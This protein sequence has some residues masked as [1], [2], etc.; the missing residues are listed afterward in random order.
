MVTYSLVLLLV[1]CVLSQDLRYNCPDD[2][3]TTDNTCYKFVFSPK[4]TYEK[5]R[6]TCADMFASLISITDLTEHNFIENY[7]INNDFYRNSWYTRGIQDFSG[8][9]S[10]YWDGETTPIPYTQQY[11]LPNAQKSPGVIIVYSYAVSKYGWSLAGKN[12]VLPYIC[13]I[14]RTFAY[15]LTMEKRTFEFGIPFQNLTNIQRGPI[16]QAQPES[17][18][19]VSRTPIANVECRA[20]CYPTCR[21]KWFRGLGLT[22]EVSAST[23]NRYTMTNGKLSIQDPDEAKDASTYQCQVSNEIGTVISNPVQLA[24][25]SLGEFSNV[26]DAPVFANAYEGSVIHCSHIKADPAA[27]YMWLRGNPP[28]EIITETTPYTFM[29]ANGRLY[30]SEVTLIDALD[31]YCQ[32]SLT[33]LTT[34]SLGTSQAPSR[35][36]R[37]I[38]MIVRQKAPM[39]N[40]GPDIQ[41]DFIYVSP[42]RP[43]KGFNVRMECFAYGSAVNY[44][45]TWRYQWSR[46]GG[47]IPQ[48]AK[49]SDFN[50]VM[51]IEN[52]QPEDEGNYLCI[53]SRGTTASSQKNLYLR[54]Y[55]VPYYLV[56]LRPQHVDLGSDLTW[57]CEASGYP[58]PTYSWY[59][60]GKLIEIIPGEINVA[61]NTLTI[62]NLQLKHNGMYQCAAENYLGTSMSEAQLRVLAF[63]PTFNKKPLPEEIY[64]AVNGNITI[65]C[66][67][68]AAPAPTIEWYI[69]ASLIS[70]TDKFRRELNGD[71]VIT[72]LGMADAGVY[73]CKATNDLGSTESA[74]RL[75]VKGQVAI[76]VPP[77]VTDKAVQNETKFIRCEAS[78]DPE[79]DLVYVWN[80]NGHRINIVKDFHY[81]QIVR[82]GYTGLMIKLIQFRHGGDYE[83]IAKTPV[84]EARASGFL[85]I[86]GPPSEPAGVTADTT[87]TTSLRLNWFP[88]NTNGLAVDY[89]TIQSRVQGEEGVMTDWDY[90][91]NDDGGRVFER[92]VMPMGDARADRRSYLVK[93]LKPGN[94]YQF[95]VAAKNGYAGISP[96]SYPS[97]LTKT[98]EAAPIAMPSLIYGGNGS[99]GDLHIIWNEMPYEDRGHQDGG[100]MVYWRQFQEGS[101]QRVWNKEKVTSWKQTHFVY[102]VGEENFYLLYEI[103]IQ[104]WNVIG[105][106]PNA[107]AMIYSSEGMPTAAPG[108]VLADAF[109]STAMEV[110]WDAVEDTRAVMKGRLYGYQ[111]NYYSDDDIEPLYKTYIRFPGQMESAVCIGLWADSNFWFQIQVYNTAG[112]GPVSDSYKQETL[113]LASRLYPTEVAVHSHS[114]TSVVVSWRGI[115]I[116]FDEATIA[117][118][119]LYLWP[120]NEHFRS[121]EEIDTDGLVTSYVLTNLKKGIIYAVRVA[122]MSDGGSG[123]K[124]ITLYFTLTGGSNVAIDQ[125]LTEFRAGADAVFMSVFLLIGSFLI[126]INFWL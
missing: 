107:S 51:T 36:S 92:D 101:D 109:N 26:K 32:V 4:L 126:S 31:Y 44:G 53:V 27:T 30:F 16:F 42:E 69:G 96:Q 115:L 20:S 55:A 29:S 84:N 45:S 111:I 80:L 100:Y 120:S 102:Q 2:W 49:F 21:Y 63:K 5:A 38:T 118:Y 110:T 25:G 116:E 98:L 122:A 88:G 70:S 34:S 48:N 23:D 91:I 103:K 86:L 65:Q 35:V 50:R 61:G 74:G 121:A 37:P 56:P 95:R 11:W 85:K 123:K 75:F 6:K 97:A 67:P 106:G 17:V 77:A 108:N 113:H 78:Y 40:W 18:M 73:R 66:R 104:G 3:V 112:L 79:L 59:K 10:W 114:A 58:Y 39:T 28:R 87:M 19:V 12:K 43:L 71:L 105:S 47:Q 89:Y 41:D 7:L 99:V 62:F 76:S 57:K 90:I 22:E 60:D 52:S 117:N 15:R 119:R 83:C 1:T 124:S 24:F 8:T 93:N 54:L 94:Q 64:G 72:G 81:E 14:P 13:E 68:E 46:P 125:T 82:P 9:N 33:S